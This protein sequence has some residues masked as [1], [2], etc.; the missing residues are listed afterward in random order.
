MSALN[1]L[2]PG[3]SAVIHSFS[4]EETAYKFLSMGI[5]PGSTV[6]MIRKAPFGGAFYIKADYQQFAIRNQ[7]AACIVLE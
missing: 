6:E 4:D 7:E 5:L 2:K 1:E 3:E